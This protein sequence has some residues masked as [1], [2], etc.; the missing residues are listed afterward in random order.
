ML[1]KSLKMLS[2]SRTMSCPMICGSS[3]SGYM[4]MMEWFLQ[5]GE[6]LMRTRWACY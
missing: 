4:T 3:S 5:R 2:S 1:G 6:V